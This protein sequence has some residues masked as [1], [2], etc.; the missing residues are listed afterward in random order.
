MQDPP[1]TKKKVVKYLIF[2][3]F[4]SSI[5]NAFVLKG[6]FHQAK[7][8]FLGIGIS[9]FIPGRVS[10]TQ[11]VVLIHTSKTQAP[12]SFTRW[13][14]QRLAEKVLS[15]QGQNGLVHGSGTGQLSIARNRHPTL[16]CHCRLLPSLTAQLHATAHAH[17]LGGSP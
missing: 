16:H 13:D 3:I 9:A 17:P 7:P 8:F 4:L 14:M 5:Q 1:P 10:T 12:G 2:D 6:S 11:V 15:I